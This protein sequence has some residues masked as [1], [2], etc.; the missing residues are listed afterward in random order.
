MVWSAA[1]RLIGGQYGDILI[2]CA[3]ASAVNGTLWL[4]GYLTG[5]RVR[6]AGPTCPACR[7]RLPPRATVCPACWHDLRP[8]QAAVIIRLDEE[9]RRRRAARG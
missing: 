7:F 6:Q 2:T 1:Q 8:R 9:R 5:R 4:L 3:I